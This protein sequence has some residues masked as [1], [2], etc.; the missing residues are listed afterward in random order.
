MATVN[1]ITDKVTRLSHRIFNTTATE[2]KVVRDGNPFSKSN[3][4]K[5]ILM[6]DVFQSSTAKATAGINDKISAGTKRIY[7]MF[8]GSITDFGN[9]IIDGIESV[10]AFCSKVKSN[11]VET[12][13][14]VYKIANT[15]IRFDGLKETLQRDITSFFPTDTGKG[16]VKMSKMDPHT[17]IKPMFTEA[18][19]ALDADLAAYAA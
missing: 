1:K 7:S 15:E 11:A 16:I 14:K 6:E 12:W 2:T 13:N 18:L 8:V 3:F 5:N 17:E 9:T 19:A 10:K 4:Q